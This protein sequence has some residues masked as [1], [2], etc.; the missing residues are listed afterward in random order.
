MKNWPRPEREAFELYYVE[1]LEP[2]EIELVTG[3]PLKTVQQNLASVQQ[4]IRKELFEQ[5]AI[6]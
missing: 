1:G 6:A 5:E 4:H 2:E 3:Q